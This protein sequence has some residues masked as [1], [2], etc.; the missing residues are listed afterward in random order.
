MQSMIKKFSSNLVSLCEFFLL[1]SLL[2]VGDFVVQDIKIAPL[3]FSCAFFYY[4]IK[5]TNRHKSIVVSLNAG[6]IFFLIVAISTILNFGDGIYQFWYLIPCLSIFFITDAL[7]I[8]LDHLAL[9]IFLFAI[10]L[11]SLQ[12]SWL[13]SGG[14]RGKAI[15]GPNILYRIFIFLAILS[16]FR[17]KGLMGL[18]IICLCVIGVVLTGSRGGLVVGV[19]V[20]TATIFSSRRLEFNKSVVFLLFLLP[21]AL[22]LFLP[23]IEVLSFVIERL[24]LFAGGSS[25]EGRLQFFY[26]SLSILNGGF[27]DLL[28]GYGVYPNEILKFY[29][30]NIF[31][32]LL[33]SHGILASIFFLFISIYIFVYSVLMRKK[34]SSE[35][36]FLFVVFVL[37]FLSAQFSGSFYDNWTCLTLAFCIFG[38][39][40]KNIPVSRDISYLT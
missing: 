19:L 6:L 1:I 40:L 8:N 18:I 17:L 35:Q 22:Y 21:F 11:I 34:I 14:M 23:K 32:E 4:F 39:Y 38:S 2:F 5:S 29:P 37:F 36:Q 31:L 26:V 12:L 27:F 13:T 15:F 33:V 16:Y 25:I 9:T 10:L 30:H 3:V 20:V 28:F 7:K 24:F